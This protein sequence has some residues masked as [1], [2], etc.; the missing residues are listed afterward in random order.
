LYQFN[1]KKKNITQFGY[2][3]EPIAL[4]PN[5]KEALLSMVFQRFSIMVKSVIGSRTFLLDWDTG[6]HIKIFLCDLNNA[7]NVTD[8]HRTKIQISFKKLILNMDE[9]FY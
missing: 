2:Q 4:E 9:E 8:F 5:L 1:V 6:L 3:L 7:T